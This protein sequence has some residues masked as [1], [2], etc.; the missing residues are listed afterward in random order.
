MSSGLDLFVPHSDFAETARRPVHC[1]VPDDERTERIALRVFLCHHAIGYNTQITSGIGSFDC[2]GNGTF[3]DLRE[4]MGFSEM[5]FAF[6]PAFQ[7][8][9]NALAG[10]GQRP[11]YKY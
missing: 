1:E 11:A 5:A 2:Y 4:T 7:A 3:E 10:T 9:Q 6:S 8:R